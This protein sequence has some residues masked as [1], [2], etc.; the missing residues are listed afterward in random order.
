MNLSRGRR[1][2]GDDIARL[3]R[4]RHTLGVGVALLRGRHLAALARLLLGK[5]DSQR[6]LL[7]KGFGRRYEDVDIPIVRACVG[8]NGLLELKSRDRILHAQNVLI[9]VDPEP[10]GVLVLDPLVR[11]LACKSFCIG[12]LPRHT[13]P[14]L[15]AF[16]TKKDSTC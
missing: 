9:E 7:D 5:I 13:D 11:P 15:I 6:L 2:A 10:L 8:G 4:E 3:L 1:V 12:F 14:H 16:S